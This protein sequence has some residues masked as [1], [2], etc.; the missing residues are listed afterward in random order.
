MRD[1]NSIDATLEKLQ[2]KSFNYFLHETSPVNGL[3]I[4]KNEA[5]WPASIAATGL[6]LAAYPVAVER[7]FMPRPAAG[8]R[9]LNTLRFFWNSPQGP[10]PDATGYKGFYY[11]FLDAQSGRRV[12]QCELPTFD[13]AFLLIW[14]LTAGIYFD[15]ET[16]LKTAAGRRIFN[17]NTRSTTCSSS[18]P[19]HAASESRRAK[20]RVLTS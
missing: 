16:I 17:N 18:P 4:D 14:A 13:S 20:D 19:T 5:G 6:A 3:V 9:K 10:E 8:R 1:E 12:W 7:G 15:A 2:H 11:H